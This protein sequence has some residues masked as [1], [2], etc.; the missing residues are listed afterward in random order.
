MHR[1]TN[2][3]LMCLLMIWVIGAQPLQSATN[4]REMPGTSL[5]SSSVLKVS[6]ESIPEELQNALQKAGVV[7]LMNTAETRE[8]WQKVMEALESLT[9]QVKQKESLFYLYMLMF[10][11]RI[12]ATAGVEHVD[13][14]NLLSYGLKAEKIGEEI[15]PLPEKAYGSLL[16]DI[17]AVEIKAGQYQDALE[18]G[19]QIVQR[20]RYLE[21]L[22]EPYLFAITAVGQMVAA[23]LR[24]PEKNDADLQYLEE[25]E[26]ANRNN[27]LGM[28]TL[29]GLGQ[30]AIQTQHPDQLKKYITLLDQYS[31][32]RTKTLR[33]MWNRWLADHGG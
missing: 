27:P 15:T 10:K 22:G 9:D 16:L 6:L 25:I 13:W 32:E 20:Y 18:L 2:V 29:A 23:Y 31:N 3:G 5:E 11:S 4:D 21:D 33:A 12:K 19:K 7:D 26:K 30:I 17:Q 8:D 24:S 28:A 14:D 1:W